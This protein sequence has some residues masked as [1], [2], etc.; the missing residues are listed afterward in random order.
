MVA[1]L[2]ASGEFR[3]SA[4]WPDK[5]SQFPLLAAY[6]SNR[7]SAISSMHSYP[8]FPTGDRM[9]NEPGPWVSSIPSFGVFFHGRDGFTD[10]WDM[11]KLGGMRL[12]PQPLLAGF[13][14]QNRARNLMMR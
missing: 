6:S 3:K 2:P 10:R 11:E 7:T 8:I 14:L 12:W 4:R 9:G 5:G 1:K 13:L